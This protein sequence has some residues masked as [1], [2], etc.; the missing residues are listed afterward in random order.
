MRKARTAGGRELT[1]HDDERDFDE[2]A[3]NQRILDTGD[4]EIDLYP[5]TATLDEAKTKLA[6]L[7]ELFNLEDDEIAFYIR[8]MFIHAGNDETNCP[9]IVSDMPTVHMDEA[10][11]IVQFLFNLSE[12]PHGYYRDEVTDFALTM[13]LCPIHFVDY[14]ICFDDEDPDCAQVRAIHPSHDT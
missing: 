10:W 8:D 4:G 2:E 12:H 3:A 5:T 9:D 1:M 13:S 6:R 7:N 14:A 11:D